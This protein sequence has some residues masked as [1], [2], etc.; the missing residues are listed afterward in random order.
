MKMINSSDVSYENVT[1]ILEAFISKGM[2]A[3]IPNVG[4]IAPGFE[5]LNSQ[6][7]KFQLERVLSDGLNVLLIFYRGH[8]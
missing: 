7:E 6:G 4:Q 1:P 5:I 2:N 3:E 8:W